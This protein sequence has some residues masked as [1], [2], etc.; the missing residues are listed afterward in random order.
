VVDTGDGLS[1]VALAAGKVGPD[2]VDVPGLRDV[3]V[4]AAPALVKLDTP[5]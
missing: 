5:V 4:L 2:S 3:A 1:P